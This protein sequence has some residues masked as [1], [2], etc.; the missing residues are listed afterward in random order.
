M[1]CRDIFASKLEEL[2]E[3]RHNNLICNNTK[4]RIRLAQNNLC[5]KKKK[6]KHEYDLNK[7]FQ[8]SFRKAEM[9]GKRKEK[10]ADTWNFLIL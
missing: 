4:Q 8:K 6:R 3:L 7:I 2:L 9:M 1:H 5:K 10:E